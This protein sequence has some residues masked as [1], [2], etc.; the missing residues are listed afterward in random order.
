MLIIVASDGVLSEVDD[1]VEEGGGP[2]CKTIGT[3]PCPGAG[4]SG[5]ISDKLGSSDGI[6]LMSMDCSVARY[7]IA[8]SVLI[9]AELECLR[10]LLILLSWKA[11]GAQKSIKR[12]SYIA[13]HGVFNKGNGTLVDE[14]I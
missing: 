12:E 6:W 2:V 13:S 5:D 4:I 10:D 9:F 8:I 1:F 3:V 7:L 14:L 11:V